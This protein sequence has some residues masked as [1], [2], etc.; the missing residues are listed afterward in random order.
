MQ[1]KRRR[2]AKNFEDIVN[3]TRILSKASSFSY[4]LSDVSMNDHIQ[5]DNAIK[6]AQ[7]AP[8]NVHSFHRPNI[9]KDKNR[10]KAGKL[11]SAPRT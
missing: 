1:N 2:V 5:K 7:V 4:S 9:Q 11:H 3:V 6:I 8:W 10:K